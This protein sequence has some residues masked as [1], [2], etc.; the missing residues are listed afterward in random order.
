MKLLKP[1]FISTVIA[2]IIT[3]CTPKLA[4]IVATNPANIDQTLIKTTPLKEEDLR[5]WSHLDMAKDTIPGMSVDRT[6]NELLKSK[7]GTKIIV[8]VIDSGV[9][10]DHEDLK[11]KI[12]SNKKEIAGNKKDDDNNG[13][14]DD[15]NGWNFLGEA[16]DE[17]L[18]LT[19]IVKKG[20][21]NSPDYQAA[22]A[23]LDAK[24]SE[25]NQQKPQVDMIAK[26]DKDVKTLLKKEKYTLADIKTI[27]TTDPELSKSKAI[28][29]QIATQ[30]GEGFQEE[31]NSYIEYVYDNLNYN[32]NVNFDGRKAVG[33]NPNDIN[34]KKYGNGNV[35]GPDVEDALHGTHVAGIIA[36]IRGNK[37][38][39]DG[40]INNVEIMAIRAVPNGDEY[41]KD[42]A[43]AIRYAV[44]NGAKVINGSF[45]K[46]YSPNKEWVFD[47]IK[48]AASKDVL[49]VHAAGNDGKNIDVEPNFPND[50]KD[51]ITEISDNVLTIGA[52]N[53][54]CGSKLVASFSN[55]GK[56]NV[57]VF[58][59]GMEIYAT[60]PNNK[61]KMEQGTSMA[62]PNVA[63]VAALIR[64]YYPN[65]TA[66]QVK[67]IIMD[68]G[69]PISYNVTLGEERKSTSFSETCVSGKI[70]NAYNAILMAE[71]MS[72]K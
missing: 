67:H 14:V 28:M 45:G 50:S 24:L 15:V 4:P 12:W 63:G 58:S 13:F 59:P 41:D 72:K 6:Y 31:I 2:L 44:D 53:S 46:D 18:E 5:R 52:L 64:S 49:F 22:K 25:L 38:G 68:S 3:S 71:Q 70:V 35:K 7:K 33:D 11:G 69:T 27:T 66:S 19:R 43:L 1:I 30:A 32:L 54:T 57:D 29:T 42:I 16:T 17:N 23:E 36:Q 34:D 48:Y 21:V 60:V 9:D 10:V 62:S 40:V 20:D 51:K 61:Y 39:G 65:L 47:A 26:A 55:F 8:G 56:M 37:K